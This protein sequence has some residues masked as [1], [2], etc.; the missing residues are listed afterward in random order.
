MVYGEQYDG[1]PMYHQFIIW[2]ANIHTYGMPWTNMPC[3]GWGGGKGGSAVVCNDPTY[4][5]TEMPSSTFQKNIF[6]QQ[7]SI[8]R[9]YA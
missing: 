2:Y 6:L 1:I 5:L 4:F 9:T 3:T 8:Y 7:G